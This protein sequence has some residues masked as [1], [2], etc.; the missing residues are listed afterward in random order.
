MHACTYCIHVHACSLCA[1]IFQYFILINVYCFQIE[2]Y[3]QISREL[4][5]SIK[6]VTFYIILQ[7]N[8][9]LLRGLPYLSPKVNFSQTFN[10]STLLISYVL[11]YHCSH[12]ITFIILE[13]LE[14]CVLSMQ[15]KT[16]SN[17]QLLLNISLKNRK[18]KIFV[19]F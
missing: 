13:K 3:F 12:F 1:Y 7:L 11:S 17:T 18:L 14:P 15:S 6:S 4:S 8:S 16:V 19:N 2:L 5:D 10:W 9:Q